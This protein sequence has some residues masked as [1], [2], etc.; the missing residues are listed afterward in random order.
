[1][2]TN[3]KAP[4]PKLHVVEIFDAD[5]KLVAGFA[6]RETG[7]VQAKNVVIDNRIVVRKATELEIMTIAK[8]NT[9]ILGITPTALDDGQ[10]DF[11]N[12]GTQG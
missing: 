9:P 8:N 5:N 7:K 11:V 2:S 4:E 10:G 3:K 6:V 1:M 12:D